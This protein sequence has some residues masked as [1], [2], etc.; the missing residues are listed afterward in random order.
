[1]LHDNIGSLKNVIDAYFAI[2]INKAAKHW[3]S[4]GLHQPKSSPLMGADTRD[5]R[6]NQPDIFAH[7]Y[8]PASN[9][10]LMSIKS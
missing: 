3:L 8:M 4:Y 2:H 7:R 6:T 1:M 10:L 5:N 9:S